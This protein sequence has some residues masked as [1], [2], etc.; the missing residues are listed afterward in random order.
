[1]RGNTFHES[2]YKVADVKPCLHVSVKVYRQRYRGEIWQVIRDTANNNFYRLI[3]REV[4]EAQ[5][6]MKILSQKCSKSAP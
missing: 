2:W 6:P 1:M 5:L 3:S 4:L